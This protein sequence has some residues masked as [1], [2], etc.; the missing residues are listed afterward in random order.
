LAK[1]KGT[2]WIQLLKATARTDCPLL[3]LIFA[4]HA[5]FVERT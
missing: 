2:T 1:V 3:T 5:E 4:L